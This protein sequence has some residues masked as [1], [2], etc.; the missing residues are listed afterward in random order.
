[1]KPLVILDFDGTI[2]EIAKNPALARVTG[3]EKL[4][5]EKL[6]RIADV[7]ILTGR[8][9]TFVRKQIPGR[10]IRVLGLHGNKNL[11]RTPALK[12]AETQVRTMLSG[13]KG[14]IFEEKSSGFVV[15]YRK[16]PPQNAFKVRRAVESTARKFKGKIKL[17]DARKA[18]EFLAHD[19]KTKK[20]TLR[21]IV[22]ENK[23]RL[24]VFVGDDQSDCEA[25]KMCSG[26]KNFFGAM[27]ASSEIGCK[28]AR[29]INRKRL[30]NFLRDT[31][32]R[33]VKHG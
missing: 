11:K 17:V 31:V 1:M 25:I 4:G 32:E 8:P 15:H 18:F 10:K 21:E 20:D 7:A 13:T 29:K 12:Q 28:G 5:L 26:K 3:K 30:F 27:I 6:S 19:A 2:V 23:G 9:S 16:V 33:G 22:E 14:I 24:V